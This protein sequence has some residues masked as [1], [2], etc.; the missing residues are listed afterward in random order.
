MDIQP[1]WFAPDDIEA[2][3]MGAGVVPVARDDRGQLRLLLGRERYVAH[4]K[5][6]CRWS[7]FEGSRKAPETLVATAVREFGEES[8]GVVC[9]DAAARLDRG[10]YWARIVLRVL[11]ERRAERYHATYV[12]PVAWD[13]ALPARFLRTRLGLEHVDRAAQEWRYARPVVLGDEDDAEMEVGEVVEEEEEEGEDEHEGVAEGRPATAVVVVVRRRVR[14]A[15]L[16]TPPWTEEA[17]E[18]EEKDDEDGEDAQ[19][20]RRR[21]TV[22][23]VARLRGEA[24]EGMRRWER[25]RQRVECALFDHPGLRVRRGAAWG[26]LQAV[27]VVRDHLEKDQVRWWSVPEL[28]QVLEGRGQRGADRFRPYFLPVLQTLLHQLKS[29]NGPPA[30]PPCASPPPAP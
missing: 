27:E 20:A 10:D 18:E 4:W 12:L 21:H 11:S 3:G 13:E 30:A 19:P 28:W 1:A 24:A 16:A 7:G 8:L 22:V 14:R 5:G 2:R 26:Q 25:L 15:V 6:S 17:Q 9:P 23:H 29:A